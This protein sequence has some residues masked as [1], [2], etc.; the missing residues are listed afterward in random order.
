[1]SEEITVIHRPTDS[2]VAI[3]VTEAEFLWN[4]SR[5]GDRIEPCI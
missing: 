4:V 3:L 2:V 1:M 5:I